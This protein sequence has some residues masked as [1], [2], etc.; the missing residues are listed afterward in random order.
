MIRNHPSESGAAAVELALVVMFILLPILGIAVDLGSALMVKAQLDEAAAEGSSVA[1]HDP[2]DHATATQRAVESV[3]IVN[4]S[5]ADVAIACHGPRR[6]AASVTHAYSPVFA[7]LFGVD[8]VALAT[9]NVS[10]VL[11]EDDC[12]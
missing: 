9:T 7:S 1:A 2:T 5:A 6:V 4:L 12:A 8:D 3:S 10:D 11:T